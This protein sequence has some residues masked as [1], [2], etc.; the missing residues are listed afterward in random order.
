MAYNHHHDTAVVGSGTTLEKVDMD[1]PDV[2]KAGRKYIRLDHGK[3]WLPREHSPSKRGLPTSA[4]F[5]DG[6]GGEYRKS[7]H[8]YAPPFA[9]IVE[10]P[11][12]FAGSP[13]QIDTWN[14]DNMSITGAPHFVPGPVPKHNLAPL[15]GPDAV[16]SGLLECPLTTRIKKIYN[17]GSEGFNDSVKAELF[18]CKKN[19][20]NTCDTIINAT[21]ACFDA[22]KTLGVDGNVTT[23][24]VHDPSSPPGCSLIS[25]PEGNFQLTFNKD[26]GSQ[27]C[28]G[29]NAIAGVK[30]SLVKLSLNVT[31]EE[32]TITMTGPDKVWFGVGFDASLMVERPYTIVV[33]GK[34]GVTERKLNNHAAGSILT[35]SVKVVSNVVF[36]GTRTVVL[37]R[38][39]TGVSNDHYT[40][41]AQAL[42]L[43]FINAIGSGP[44]FAFHKQATA[45]TIQLWP[46][47]SSPVCVCAQPALPFGQASGYVQYL[48]TGEKIGFKANRC[49]PKP[50]EDLLANR[51]PTCDIRTC[52]FRKIIVFHEQTNKRIYQAVIGQSTWFS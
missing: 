34:G 21:S 45:E 23:R 41:D 20:K 28:C 8:I 16:Y 37:S 5:S 19:T 29:A 18:E 36:N 22:A 52:T 31:T 35:T 10:S 51:N 11:E 33:D 42:S 43:N 39:A 47:A 1:H 3:V 6:N 24:V 9:Q 46:S 49:P 44:D 38:A 15:T 40:F 12:R 32:V 50:R 48:P 27:A 25:T 30:S 17:P 7:Y 14:R 26:L 4:M 2:K 13:M